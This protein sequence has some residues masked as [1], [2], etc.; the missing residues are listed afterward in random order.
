MYFLARQGAHSQHLVALV[1]AL[2]PSSIIAE[3]GVHIELLPFKGKDASQ[4]ACKLVQVIQTFLTN[5]T[6]GKDRYREATDLGRPRQSKP[7]SLELV[8]A[9][10]A[11][12]RQ[13]LVRDLERRA[14]DRIA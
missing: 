11:A 1:D 7:V 3:G 14:D 6:G 12:V 13:R 2:L 8:D 4:T 9:P 10:C 5:R